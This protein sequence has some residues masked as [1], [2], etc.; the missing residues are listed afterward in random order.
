M[1]THTH[2]L[3][4]LALVGCGFHEGAV[5]S[6]SQ[7]ESAIVVPDSSNIPDPATIPGPVEVVGAEHDALRGPEPAPTIDSAPRGSAKLSAPYLQAAAAMEK[8]AI[9]ERQMATGVT[10]MGYALPT[11]APPAPPVPPPDRITMPDRISPPDGLKD[12]GIN[13]FVDTATDPL[14]TFAVDVDT[15]SYTMTRR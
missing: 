2:V 12:F 4:T 9:R 1:R 8:P 13:G 15:A 11:L 14:S 7:A 5:E 6:A 10:D 3:V